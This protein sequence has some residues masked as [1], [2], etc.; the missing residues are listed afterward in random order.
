MQNPLLGPEGASAVYGPQKGASPDDV[1]RLDRSLANFAAIVERDLGVRIDQ[2][3]GGG[4]AGGLAAGLVAFCG[5]TLQ[6]GF[7]AVADALRLADRIARADL[8]VTGEG[9]LDA[10]SGYGK[11]VAG[12][13]ALADSMRVPCLAVAGLIEGESDLPGI[14]DREASD[15]PGTAR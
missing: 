11:T 13:S 14:A 10:Q 2:I 9:R 3:A 8:V 7:D 1:A 4:A 15:S 5:A 6:S 12:V